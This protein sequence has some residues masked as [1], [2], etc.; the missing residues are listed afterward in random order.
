MAHLIIHGR[1][2]YCESLIVRAH[3]EKVPRQDICIQRLAFCGSH[4]YY[5]ASKEAACRE[6]F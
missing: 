4:V 1:D 2:R 5:G 3:I 6:G